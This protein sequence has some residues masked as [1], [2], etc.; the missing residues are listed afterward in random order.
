ML[1]SG[2]GCV[3]P[4]NAAGV[5]LSSVPI[6]LRLALRVVPEAGVGAL[7]V[8][9]VKGQGYCHDFYRSR[10][11]SLFGRCSVVDVTDLLAI[12][13]P[14]FIFH[15]F[16]L[17]FPLVYLT[18]CSPHVFVWYCLFVSGARRVLYPSCYFLDAFD[19]RCQ[20]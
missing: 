12:A 13:D 16:C 11:L 3:G 2:G 7:L 1:G 5:P 6:A 17:V 18:L 15:L 4:V 10:F 8:P 20:M 14:F 19:F 9:R